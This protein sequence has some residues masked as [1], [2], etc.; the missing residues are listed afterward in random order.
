MGHNMY[1][2]KL[3]DKFIHDRLETWHAGSV[4]VSTYDK[5]SLH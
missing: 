3:R 1:R 2:I 5:R 4:V